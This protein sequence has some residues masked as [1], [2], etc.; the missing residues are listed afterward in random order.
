LLSKILLDIEIAIVLASM[1]FRVSSALLYSHPAGRATSRLLTLN[2]LYN[3]ACEKVL[4][5]K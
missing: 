2:T 5:L 3:P 1:S 4:S